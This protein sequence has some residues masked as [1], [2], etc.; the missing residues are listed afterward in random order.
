MTSEHINT[1]SSEAQQHFQHLNCTLLEEC[2]AM[3]EFSLSTGKAPDPSIIE[4]VNRNV[5]KQAVD[6]NDVGMLANL[7][8]KLTLLISPVTPNGICLLQQEKAKS[9]ILRFMGPVPLVRQLTLTS[10][11]FLFMMILV[12]LSTEVNYESISRGIL[13]SDGIK[14]LLNLLFLLSCAGLGACFSALYQLNQFIINANYDP[15]FDSTYW[16]KI[17]LGIIAGLFM[18]ELMPPDLFQDSIHAASTA[19]NEQTPVSNEGDGGS[20]N[21]SIQTLAKPALAL[22]GGFSA[23]MVYR[24]LQRLVDS[25][26][27][28]V[29]GDQRS[30]I[31]AKDEL[32]TVLLEQHKQA[33][34]MNMAGDLQ[35]LQEQILQ[36][37]PEKS[38]ALIQKML[39]EIN[40]NHQIKTQ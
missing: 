17:L 30:L 8:R 22:L 31:R 39:N 33:L 26:E 38:K 27:S 21:T 14:L 36:N 3:A 40:P 37:D 34:Q 28:F 15:K 25:I 7:H 12:G 18:V 5:Q 2:A 16:I 35:A 32:Q 11:I 24:V 1:I 29:K 13:H 9:H 10:L 4:Q 23:T 19:N 20:I 6:G